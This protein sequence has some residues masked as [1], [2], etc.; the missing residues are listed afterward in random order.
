MVCAYS[1]LLSSF[2][3]FLCLLDELD[4]FTNTCVCMCVC[5]SVWHLLFSCRC[6]HCFGIHLFVVELYGIV[7]HI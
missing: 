5:V 2:A 7:L 3:G 4:T 6:L 1:E